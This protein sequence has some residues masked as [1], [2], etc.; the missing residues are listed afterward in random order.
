MDQINAA[1]GFKD[2]TVEIPNDLKDNNRE[3][4]QIA[5]LSTMMIASLITYFSSK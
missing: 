1:F 3:K 5:V 2:L 4:H